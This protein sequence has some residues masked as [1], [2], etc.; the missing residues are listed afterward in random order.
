MSRVA[1]AVNWL[2]AGILCWAGL[3][4]ALQPIHFFADQDWVQPAV[5]VLL[6][7]A[8]LVSLNGL[9][10]WVT[11]WSAMTYRRVL[12]GVMLLIWVTQIIVAWQFVDVGRADA[13]FVRNQAI[14]LAQGRHHW[15]DYFLVYPNN[16]NFT[17]LEAALIKLGLSLGLQTPWVA[18]NISRFLWLDTGLAAGLVIIKHWQR[19]QPGALALAVTWLL[20]VPI[21]AFGLFAYTDALVMPLTV[22]VLALAYLAKRTFGWRQL[23]LGWLGLGLVAL[24]VAMKANLIVLWLALIL[25]LMVA[26]WQQ[27]VTWT[28][29]VR[30]V[31]ALGLGIFGMQLWAHQSGYQKQAAVALPTTSWLAMSLNPKL[32]GQYNATDMQLIRQQ[33][34]AAKKQQTAQKL[35]RQRLT[36]MGVWGS[37]THL[38]AKFR[39][40]WATGDF[41]SFKLTTQWLRAPT[42]Y[43][44]G[45]RAWQFWL[46]TGTQVGFLA[47]LL[48]SIWT[49]VTP[50]HY[51]FGISLL[52]LMIVGLTLFHVGLWEVEARYALPLLPVLML[53]GINGWMTIPVWQPQRRKLVS[54]LAGW[55]TIFSFISIL[56]TSQ[57]RSQ[58]SQIVAR[59]G[60]GAYFTATSQAL[61]PGQTKTLL[62]PTSGVSNQVQLLPVTKKGRV[63][64]TI[65]TRQGLVRQVTGTPNQLAQV[66][67]PRTAQRQLYLQLRNIG[68]S[69]V[70]Y[71]VANAN[72]QQT[73]GQLLK[74]PQAS[75]RYYIVNTHAA[76]TLTRTSTIG[77]M[78]GAVLVAVLGSVWYRPRAD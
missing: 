21:Y 37:L 32:A 31:V 38:F 13:Y 28:W 4:A 19:W 58:T 41:D 8:L 57:N 6:V 27:C 65:S 56:Q 49:L 71:S 72:Y 48:G 35:I 17:L 2:A 30:A 63:C 26:V 55:L 60:N 47:L 3:F 15:N 59:Q 50:S 43:L 22:D 74:R 12:I 40:F 29:L 24:G 42:W 66:T 78:L 10:R 46:V 53:L 62:I 9:R 33:P 44:Q 51:R 7:L 70:N 14:V 20:S 11:R 67:Y 75:W 73:T 68:Q 76:V 34:S 52:A 18:L 54:C 64:L 5:M 1:K 36:K 16:V 45:Q 23:V 69:A 25:S 77:L 61:Q 39:V